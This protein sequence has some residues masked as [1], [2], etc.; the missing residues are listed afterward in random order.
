VGFVTGDTLGSAAQAFLA[1][2]A[3]PVLEKPFMPSSVRQLLAEIRAA[4][5]R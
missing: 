5:A 2:A 3:R 1:R 4:V